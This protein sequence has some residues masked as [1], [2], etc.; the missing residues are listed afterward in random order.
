ML[1]KRLAIGSALMAGGRLGVKVL[2]LIAMLI[3]ARILTPADFGLVALATATLVIVT[4]LTDLPVTL[5]LIQ[6]PNLERTDCD[7]AFTL[8]AVRGVVVFLVMLGLAWGL[9]ALYADYRIVGIISIFGLV[10]L[11]SSLTSPMMV[12]FAREVRFGPQIGIEVVCKTL[13]FGV[14][15]AFV[16]ATH[17][18]WAL[19]AGPVG[20]A[21]AAAGA[22]YAVAPYR[23]RFDLS[24]ARTLIGFSG[25]MSLG[26]AVQAL[27]LQSD[28]LLIGWLLGKPALGQYT[29]ASDLA[30]TA[31]YSFASPL[32]SVLFA[33]FS[34]I[35]DD[36]ERLRAGYR[37][38]QQLVVA[39]ILP[40]GVGL[41]VVADRLVNLLLGPQWSQVAFCVA[42]LAP[43][44]A[45]Q[46]MIVMVES[47][48]LS[49][50]KPR[51]VL[52]RN[53]LA[54][55][56]RTP[57]TIA[58]ALVFGLPG[59]VIARALTGLPV[60]YMNMR[61]AQRLLGVPVL[62]QALNCWRSLASAAIMAGA[63]WTV[64]A[65]LRPAHDH[66]D[67]SDALT[68]VALV[69]VGAVVYVSAHLALWRLSGR[70]TGA[71]QYLLDLAAK[72]ATLLSRKSAKTR[73]SNQSA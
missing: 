16:F 64:Q 26:Q 56:I 70:P 9:A 58:A 12:R 8:S 71:E 6:K 22:S 36:P 32:T 29:V 59:A 62:T 53:L 5:A 48:A 42:W 3:V 69:A 20:A 57:A 67:L 15:L 23:P 50:G 54:V 11:V 30:A 63:L 52:N 68:L 41:A 7:T 2:D 46:T 25:W 47:L 14:T 43:F 18:Y 33:S 35:Q 38:A 44:V 34:R 21:V 51:L 60:I 39:A 17:S 61:L 31:T 4:A 66:A 37:R 45:L 55:L 28:R 72:A 27:S 13:A 10:P 19:V 73:P 49:V 65:V 40:L 24:R 1:G